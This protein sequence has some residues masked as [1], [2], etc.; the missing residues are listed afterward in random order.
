MSGH[1][2]N[3]QRSVTS[4]YTYDIEIEIELDKETV[5]YQEPQK[6]LAVTLTK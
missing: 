1:D 5:Y 4:L 3:A 6:Y 2:I